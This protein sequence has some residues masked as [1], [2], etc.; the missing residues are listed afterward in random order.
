MNGCVPLLRRHFSPNSLLQNFH[1]SKITCPTPVST[2][3]KLQYPLLI[4]VSLRSLLQYP[5]LLNHFSDTHCSNSHLSI[6]RFS[7]IDIICRF[8]LQIRATSAMDFDFLLVSS[9]GNILLRHENWLLTKTLFGVLKGAAG[10]A[11]VKVAQ[12]E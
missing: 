10:H 12:G 5:Y 2:K 3:K 7:K 8:N 4:P 9:K 1:L 11:L 6:I